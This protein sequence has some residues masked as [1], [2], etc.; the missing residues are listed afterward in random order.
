MDFGLMALLVAGLAACGQTPGVEAGRTYQVEAEGVTEDETTAVMER[1]EGNWIPAE[2]LDIVLEE[3]AV[4]EDGADEASDQDDQD[5][6]DFVEAISNLEPFEVSYQK[7]DALGAV[8]DGDYLTGAK[9][10][11]EDDAVVI[12]LKL[13]DERKLSGLKIASVI[14]GA[15]PAAI[16]LQVSAHGQVWKN[17][18]AFEF[19][20]SKPGV[21]FCGEGQ[22]A[23][24]REP[25]DPALNRVLVD[26]FFDFEIVPVRFVRISIGFDGC[27]ERAVMIN[28]VEL[29]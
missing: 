24:D 2:R 6:R 7:G 28:E 18:G 3:S 10:V 17:L 21:L 27:R 11:C 4:E 8:L 9:F 26:S 12:N 5:W 29:F 14:G 20:A 13:T 19:G 22:V 23:S 16:N 25:C 1:V 15:R